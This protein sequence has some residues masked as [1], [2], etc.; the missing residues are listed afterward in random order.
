MAR[1]IVEVGLPGRT[2]G[3]ISRENSRPATIIVITGNPE[4]RRNERNDRRIRLLTS[5]EP[6]DGQWRDEIGFWTC[7]PRNRAVSVAREQ[8]I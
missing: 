5:A 4:V 7:C 8:R 6:K 2:K 1:C 3:G